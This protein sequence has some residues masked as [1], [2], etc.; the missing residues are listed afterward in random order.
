V[1][2]NHGP[3]E[4]S[5]TVPKYKQEILEAQLSVDNVAPI[6][7]LTTIMHPATIQNKINLID[8]ST[9]I[10][11]NNQPKISVVTLVSL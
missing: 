3:H 7:E 1:Y 2:L 9:T 10:Q 8:K 5:K 11:P 6:T 4:N